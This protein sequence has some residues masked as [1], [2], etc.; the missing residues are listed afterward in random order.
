VT[1]MAAG[2]LFGSGQSD[3]VLGAGSSGTWIYNHNA[4]WSQ[5]ALPS[6]S[7]AVTG[8]VN[9]DG[10]A[11]AVLTLSGDANTWLYAPASSAWSILL[12][13]AASVMTTADVDTSGQADV[14]FGLT[15]GLWIDKNNGTWQYL[16]AQIPVGLNG[17]SSNA[18]AHGPAVLM[19]PMTNSPLAAAGVGATG[20]DRSAADLLFGTSEFD[21]AAACWSAGPQHAREDVFS[22]LE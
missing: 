9:G 16:S 1:A 6:I 20:V 22:T 19:A 18:S 14:L 3:L 17:D 7:A 4:N 11:E 15:S 13:Q 5:I 21:A 12:G 2:N 8:D 10:K